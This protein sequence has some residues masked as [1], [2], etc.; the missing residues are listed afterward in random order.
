MDQPSDQLEAPPPPPADYSDAAD[1][2]VPGYLAGGG[3]MVG[4]AAPAELPLRGWPRALSAMRHQAYRRLWSG[5]LVSNIGSWMQNVARD[6]L[7]FELA[8]PTGKFWLGLNAFAEG[9][10]LTFLLPIGG[11]LADRFPRRWILICA[12]A[13]SA[14]L[15]L[16]LASLTIWGKLRGWH[17]IAFTAANAAMD[18]L[19]IPANQS[20]LPDLV[21]HATIPN[22][23]ALNS[24]QFNL[25]RVAG[26]ALG[27]LTLLYLGAA[28]SFSL[29]ALSFVAVIIPLLLMRHLPPPRPRTDSMRETLAKGIRYVRSR[30]DLVTMMTLVVLGGMLSAPVTK[31][32]PALSHDYYQR[33]EAG[34][35]V[36]LSC[37]GIGAVFGAALLAVRSHRNPT[38]WRA[39]PILMMLGVCQIVL[40]LNRH[41]VVGLVLVALVGMMFI[42]TMVRLNAAIMQS[43][44]RSVRGRVASFQ[45]MAFRL[46]LPIGGLLAGWVAQTAGLKWTYLSFGLAMIVVMPLL[47]LAARRR[48]VQWQTAAP[49]PDAHHG[50][51]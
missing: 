39:F 36:L 6:W 2:Q 51:L 35:S 28:W 7:V 9:I 45:V 22:A 37:F 18:A 4:T 21:D 15:A 27:G 20:L 19:R 17:I 3:Q 11:V 13:A 46:G 48:D 25:S 42:G 5:A 31:M 34:F 8:G 23:I 49:D 14:V 32:L 33:G 50:G 38:P 30:G 43:T 12:N 10:P 29:N 16:L 1:D 24:M 47:M 26:P 41:Y 40:A 44:P